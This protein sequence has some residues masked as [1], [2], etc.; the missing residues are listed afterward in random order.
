VILRP[1]AGLPEI[2]TIAALLFAGLLLSGCVAAVI[3]VVAGGVIARKQV[4]HQDPPQPVTAKSAPAPKAPPV[5][6]PVTPVPPV[7]ET[8]APPASTVM[9]EEPP[10]AEPAP[11]SL[12]SPPTGDEAED[13]PAKPD[14]ETP[15]VAEFIYPPRGTTAEF[16]KF[17]LAQQER[18]ATD[19]LPYGMVLDDLV[20][21][22]NPR[23]MTCDDKPAAVII[24]L[25]D[26]SGPDPSMANGIKP[27][28]PEDELPYNLT[29]LR[30]AGI[31]IF[32]VT[33]LYASFSEGVTEQLLLSGLDPD[34]VD[35]VLAPVSANDRK[36]VLRQNAARDHCILA[37]LGDRKSDA[38][39]AYD[40]LKTP[41]SAYL[42]DTRWDSGWFLAPGPLHPPTPATHD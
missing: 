28:R 9:A 36:E 22:Y 19:P 2:K 11:P 12:P 29:R 40:Y 15:Q 7:V 37:V 32:W 26:K 38:A 39:E 8:P 6:D 16:T 10:K 21:L 24:D 18:R 1:L 14:S 30:K 41:E 35:Q 33:D 27:F 23:F 4:E 17:A 5:I 31:R 42:L 20:D 3:P 13:A 34:K 25:D